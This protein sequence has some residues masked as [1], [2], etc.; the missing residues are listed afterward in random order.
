[1]SGRKTLLLVED[2][3]IIALAEKQLLQGE[4]Y[5]VVHVFN[6]EEAV[7]RVVGE[8]EY[9]DLVL[10]DI[11][12]GSGMD[13]T[14]AA[15]RILECRTIPVVFL[16]GHT[17][18]EYT[19]R[20]QGITSYGYIVKNSGDRVL[21]ASIK[22]AFELFEAYSA[23]RES[24]E[25]FRLLAEHAEDLIYRIDLI[26]E[27]RFAYVSPA[28]TKITGYTPEEHYADPDLGFKLVHPDDRDRLME[29]M[30]GERGFGVPLVLRW[31]RKDGTVIWTEQN[32]VA[33]YDDDGNLIAIEG[34]ARDITER[35]RAEDL[36]QQSNRRLSEFLQ[37]SRSVTAAECTGSLLQEIVDS[38]VGVIRVDSGA[39]YV[40][41]SDTS[42]RLEATTPP[43]PDD[44]PERYR[45]AD[46]R[47]HPHVR[48]AI[49]SG[50][51][52]VMPDSH[53][54]T[55]TPEEQEIVNLR[56]L[57]SNLYVPILL[58]EKP[59]GILILS[60]IGEPHT[61][62]DEEVDLLHGF[63]DQ[64]ARLIEKTREYEAAI[65]Q[66]SRTPD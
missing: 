22:M 57:R 54:A 46:L 16:S 21:L 1:M 58:R 23:L 31:C 9:F 45:L 63:A 29:A 59:L 47:N 2:E 5:D 8:G 13:G 35:R 44:F 42:I 10:M 56:N 15:V 4:G 43:L 24:E 52:V 32:N 6:G 28:A 38:A 51:S 17:E 26:P 61:F 65:A 3:A 66:S 64:A 55:L 48:R 41:Q 19:D 50:E 12:L 49:D 34:I 27:R 62:E 25:R 14:D 20:A 7:R 37:P 60:S 33:I 39:V 11:D 36:L 18:K 40:L 30:H 53:L